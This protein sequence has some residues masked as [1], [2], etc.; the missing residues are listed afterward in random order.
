MSY[1]STRF[2][3]PAR[4]RKAAKSRRLRLESLEPR[5]VLHAAD[6]IPATQY[7][8]AA[9][10]MGPLAAS[11]VA[12][13]SDLNTTF[14]SALQQL[15]E[16]AS[17]LGLQ[18]GDLVASQMTAGYSD[19][20]PS[21]FYL[22]QTFNGLAIK[23]AWL[24]FSLS[25]DGHWLSLGSNFV[26]NLSSRSADLE[27]AVDV[28]SAVKSAA[29]QLGIGKATADVTSESF[30]LARQT[31][32]ISTASLDPV[33]ASLAYFSTAAGLRLGWELV[34]RTPDGDHWYNVGVD[35][36]NGELIFQSD[37]MSDLAAYYV[38]PAPGESPADIARTYIVNPATSASPF[39]WH[40]TNGVAGSEFTDTRGNNV[41]AQE[42]ADDND[43]GGTRPDG[44]SA[45]GFFAPIDLTQSPTTY[46]AGATTNLFYWNNYLHDIHAAY[47][48]TEAAG[49][50][51]QLNY[52]GLGAGNDYVIADSQ[53]GSGFNNAN[54][55]TPPDGFNPRMQQ[56]IFTL[57][58][59]FRD[60]SLENGIITHEYGHGVSTRLTGGPA[61]SNS[62]DSLQSGGMGEGWS[63]WWAL[64]LT[65]RA[66]DLATDARPM[67]NYALGEGPTG[68]GIRRN[69]YSFSLTTNPIS[70]ADY[71][72]STEVHDSG[73]IWAS[74]L[75]DLNWLLINKYGFDADLTTGYTGSGSG[76]AG[77]KLALQLVMDALKLQPANPTFIQARDALLT[78]DLSLTQGQ[79]QREIWT[80]FSRR[81]LGSGASTTNADATTL[82]TSAAVPTQ[83]SN[84]GVIAQS[85]AG[86]TGTAPSFLDITFS[87]AIDPA[88]F[89]IAADVVSFTGP[90]G[91]NLLP[92]ITGSSFLNGNTTLRINFTAQSAQG[93]YSLVLGAD[94]RDVSG[95]Q[96]ENNGNTTTGEAGD[97]YTANFQ[98]D[99]AAL[100]VTSTNPARGS[101]VGGAF[102]ALE[103]TF[104]EPVAA[105]SVG[106]DDLQLSQGTVT[107]FTIVSPAV[108]RYDVSGLAPGL[109]AVNLKY[110]AVTDAAGFPAEFF[111]GQYGIPN[112]FVQI[113]GGAVTITDTPDGTSNDNLTLVRSG[114]NLR[115]F[116]LSGGV[117]GSVGTTAVDFQT[118]DIPFASITSITLNTLG[119]DDTVTIDLTSGDAIPSG[120]ITFN[121]G[122]NT[123]TGDRLAIVGGSQG[124]VT[125]TYTNA[126]DGAVALSAF[127]T[128]NYTGAEALGN[129]G[130]TTAAVFVPP[131]GA[132][133]ISLVDDGSTGNATSRLTSG[134]FVPTTFAH[135]ATALTIN[136]GSTDNLTLNATDLFAGTV[137][138]SG[139]AIAV[140]S[141]SAAGTITLTAS[142]SVT[143]SGT[144]T[145]ADLI[146][147]TA[148]LSAG[149]GMGAGNPLE[150]SV[151]VLEANGG[152]GGVNLANS[153]Q[154][155]IGAA[156]GLTGL[157]ATGGSIT[158]SAGGAITVNEPV[159]NSGTGS[160][161]LNATSAVAGIYTVSTPA[162]NFQDIAGSGT[163]LS[164]ADDAISSAIPLGFTF[165][166]FDVDY[167][168]IYVNSNGFLTFVTSSATNSY[169]AQ[170]FPTS[171]IPEATIG[172]FWTDINPDVAPSGTNGGVFYQT[173][174]SA[175]S[176]VF[177]AEYKALS[178]YGQTS[179]DFTFQIKLFEATNIIEVH[180]LHA[181]NDGVGPPNGNGSAGIENAAGT[182][183]NSYYF[184]TG[185]IPDNTAVRYSPPGPGNIAL[186]AAVTSGGN[187]TLNADAN[188]L[189]SSAAF[190]V[191]GNAVALTAGGGIGSAGTSVT[192]NAASLTTSSSTAQFLA[193]VAGV[194]IGAADL[195][196]GS[197]TITLTGGIFE[198]TATGGVLS[199]LVVAGGATLGGGGSATTVSVQAGG[200]IGPGAS[201]GLLNTGV[202]TFATGG[203]FTAE[204]NGPTVGTG[205][206][207]LNVTGGVTLTGAVL[208]LVL[209]YSP[210][211]ASTFT[212]INNDA[213]DAVVGTF[214]GLAE[215]ATFTVTTGA[216]TG[217]FSITYVG[218]TGND[219]VLTKLSDQ[220][221]V[222]SFTQTATGVEFTLSQA[223]VVP[224]TLNL[225]AHYQL[226]AADLQ[227]VGA[228][229]GVVAGSLT[230]DATSTTF[231]FVSSAGLLSPDIY[232]LTLRSAADAFHTNPGALLDGDDNGAAG[233]DYTRTFTVAAPALNTASLAVTSFA[234]GPDQPVNLP[235]NSTAGIPLRLTSST[236]VTQ[237]AFDLR[238][239]PALLTI[240]GVALP[241]GSPGGYTANLTQVSSGLVRVTLNFAALPLSAGPQ[242]IANLIA[243]V[244]AS[245]ANRYAE[246]NLLDITALQI[247]NG[248]VSLPAL[249]V[250]GVQANA[251][252]GDVGANAGYDSFDVQ[253]VS[254]GALNLDTIFFLNPMLS[255]LIIADF[256]GN[257]QIDSF[258]TQ[259]VSRLALNLPVDEAPPLPVP[260]PPTTTT[261][262]FTASTPTET[263]KSSSPAIT[264]A[265]TTDTA[266]PTYARSDLNTDGMIDPQDILW[267]IFYFQKSHEPSTFAASSSA[268]AAA[269]DINQDGLIAADDIL[270]VVNDYLDVLALD[271]LSTKKKA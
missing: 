212:L 252:F 189:Q 226:G 128:V 250:D 23:N 16:N 213:A 153:R 156:G 110:N 84:P 266:A 210:T 233:G 194:Q 127:G 223:V 21:H 77:N 43:T 253:Q 98:Y 169:V 269:A 96:Q 255:P 18:S 32:L 76:A 14:H 13:S 221:R 24:N 154:V 65:Q 230:V 104:S 179:S 191:T 64:M 4:R 177:V 15:T 231:R 9:T 97:R 217:R 123:A 51:Q 145:T 143:E 99:A 270:L 263:T 137:T 39:G 8:S 141:L 7:F 256:N 245:A 144:D 72:A 152:S 91:T 55:G 60:S 86:K 249:D 197:Q 261:G 34:F 25:A 108:V 93:A 117:S 47:G 80:A 54:F 155:T 57:S 148:V 78:A 66:T 201:P 219:V 160:V 50:F 115:I 102:N 235:A 5:T 79:N 114:S 209:N 243:S 200:V 28:A 88:T 105:A 186:N 140:A 132:N 45:L 106:V 136:G 166:F 175:G 183:G 46:T 103:L 196:A 190:S 162:F 195:N 119:G 142:G 75:W 85:P 87:E 244:P 185:D 247:M 184:G 168:N 240:T 120:G 100:T 134:T 180:Y 262:Q 199:P 19:D 187:V 158:L 264:T 59:P 83:F 265:N 204:L 218:G 61:N 30:D 67:G 111:E 73:E 167:T 227:L 161:T 163:R 173:S 44:G 236:P 101:T 258:D 207:Q 206:D 147:P 251:Y 6:G 260:V 170:P 214:T 1:F 113:T 237:V 62:L 149:T 205:Y 150:L 157:S 165:K 248:A 220:L 176:R 12:I 74:T 164:L 193:D 27:P 241:A 225:A 49:N 125:Y 41:Y 228:T 116:D 216:I 17:L 70:F 11:S 26:S 3:A 53:D 234:R 48:F 224:G 71:A 69:P 38:Y 121:G 95:N 254:R 31:E 10:G 246:R 238:Y 20:G 58:S 63:D 172:G 118:I 159:V 22:Q 122:T 131:T 33:P 36:A 222:Q 178:N 174:G 192:T 135:P 267:A 82:T 29:E 151:D 90:G 211:T 202:T 139:A 182:V 35:A 257:G 68:G 198:T 129:S 92:S 89:N 40:D 42:D 94:I 2:S 37:W 56:Y 268:E 208:N 171:G 107:G 130:A 259:R 203:I 239:D 271:L 133:T 109:L 81:S 215:G 52:T 232:T 181:D 138:V 126:A 242:T 112:T 188:L 146:A 124:T 229:T